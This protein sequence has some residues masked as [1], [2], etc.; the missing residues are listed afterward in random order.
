MREEILLSKWIK[1]E[2]NRIVARAADIHCWN[3]K[4]NWDMHS[5]RHG[6]A[7]IS[8]TDKIEI[9]KIMKAGGWKSQKTLL[10]VYVKRGREA[11]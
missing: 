6:R 9:D 2:A 8:L 3:T 5:M 11:K 7:V 10:N 4:L 1:T